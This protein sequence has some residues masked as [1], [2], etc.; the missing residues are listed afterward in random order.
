[1]SLST[2]CLFRRVD[3]SLMAGHPLEFGEHL[4]DQVPA[5]RI[6]CAEL[7]LASFF[8]PFVTQLSCGVLSVWLRA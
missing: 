6:L 1:M 4:P 3:S 5:G 8:E 2:C 7:G